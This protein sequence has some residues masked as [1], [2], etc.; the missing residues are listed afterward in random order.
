MSSVV[1]PKV[2]ARSILVRTL[3]AALL[4]SRPLASYSIFAWWLL[5]FAF[6]FSTFQARRLPVAA[7]A[8]SFRP[9]A[10]ARIPS[11]FHSCFRRTM[12][13]ADTAP[14][15]FLRCLCS[16]SYLGLLPLIFPSHHTSRPYRARFVPS[17]LARSLVSRAPPLVFPS[18]HP[19]CPYRPCFVP[20]LRCGSYRGAFYYC[21]LRST[22]PVANVPVSFCPCAVRRIPSPF[23]SYF[24]R[25]MAT[26][27]TAPVSFCPC[28]VGRIPSPFH[29]YF[30]RTMATSETAPVSFPSSRPDLSPTAFDYCFLRPTAPVATVPVFFVFCAVPRVTS[31][32]I[33]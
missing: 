9:H 3:L 6:S 33:S 21:L 32:S 2:T 29:S 19:S 22:P 17:L 23:H 8:V 11:P 31:A 7:L 13:P 1:K 18:H 30:L 24:L 4:P 27:E 10:V 5:S 14:V 28:A 12:P 25:T 15:S 16:C 26:S 20:T